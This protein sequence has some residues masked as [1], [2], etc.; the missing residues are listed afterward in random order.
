MFSQHVQ[1]LLLPWSLTVLA[2]IGLVLLYTELRQA[3]LRNKSKDSPMKFPD[4]KDRF[5]GQLRRAC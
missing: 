2:A 1:T 4:R 3:A 5:Q